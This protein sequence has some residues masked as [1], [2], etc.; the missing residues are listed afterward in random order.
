MFTLASLRIN[1][2]QKDPVKS[3]LCRSVTSAVHHLN[4]TR[5]SP[6]QARCGSSHQSLAEA[7]SGSLLE[8]HRLNPEQLT[9]SVVSRFTTDLSVKTEHPKNAPLY[10]PPPLCSP[11][12]QKGGDELLQCQGRVMIYSVY[13]SWHRA[14]RAQ[15]LQASTPVNSLPRSGSV[16]QPKQAVTLLRPLLNASPQR[17]WIQ[18]VLS[19]VLDSEATSIF[20]SPPTCLPLRPD[21][22]GAL[23]AGHTRS[24]STCI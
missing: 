16:S 15:S 23:E 11:I 1:S 21:R 19:D 18:T 17:L 4:R 13:G 9:S 3:V 20:P 5:P 7:D 14:I 22:A 6:T 10:P 8:A 12:Y 24:S 2:H